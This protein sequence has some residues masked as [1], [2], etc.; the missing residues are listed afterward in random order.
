MNKIDLISVMKCFCL[1]GVLVLVSACT[2]TTATNSSS[3]LDPAHT[4]TRLNSLLISTEKVG[5]QEQEAIEKQIALLLSERG[6]NAIE[7]RKLYLPTRQ[8]DDAEKRKIALGSDAKYIL[9]IIPQGKDIHDV[10]T[11]PDR[12]RPRVHIGGYGGSSSGVNVGIGFPVGVGID[13]GG[14]LGGTHFREPE[15]VYRAEIYQLPDFERIWIGE[16]SIRGPD[17]M[18][19]KTLAKRFGNSLVKELEKDGLINPL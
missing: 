12:S 3:F 6:L 14:F 2:Q 1:F 18:S 13:E 15:A 11:Y 19:W 17:G 9:V 8:Y 5:L 4:E 7:G 16:F 10:R